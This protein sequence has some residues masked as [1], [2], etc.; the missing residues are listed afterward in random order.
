MS[1]AKSPPVESEDNSK[2]FRLLKTFGPQYTFTK[3]GANCQV[4]SRGGTNAHVV[5]F[6]YI[7]E[8]IRSACFLFIDGVNVDALSTE[9]FS[10]IDRSNDE[11]PHEFNNPY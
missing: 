5:V 1:Y 2:Y 8:S 3:S 7:K 6:P 11:S 10:L 4:H 9:V